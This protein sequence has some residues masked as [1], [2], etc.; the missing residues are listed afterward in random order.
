MAANTENS[1]CERQ[2]HQELGAWLG[3]DGWHVG[4]G[5]KGHMS[6][7]QRFWGAG[8]GVGRRVGLW[9]NKMLVKNRY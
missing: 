2:R 7:R 3:Q 1:P 6:G 4:E 8:G 5:R 9:E